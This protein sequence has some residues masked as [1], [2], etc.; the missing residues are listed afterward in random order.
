MRILLVEDDIQL[1][2]GF[3]QSLRDEGFVVNHA[4]NG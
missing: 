2:S 4:A 3:Q 1:A